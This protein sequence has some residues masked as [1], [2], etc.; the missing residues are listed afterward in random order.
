MDNPNGLPSQNGLD[1]DVKDFRYNLNSAHVVPLMLSSCGLK[2]NHIL[3]RLLITLVSA[4][5][6]VTVLLLVLRWSWVELKWLEEQDQNQLKS[7]Q[8]LSLKT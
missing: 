5:L 1:V 3:S 6:L 7:S 2:E 8:M 4:V